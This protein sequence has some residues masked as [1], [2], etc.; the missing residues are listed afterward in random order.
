MHPLHEY[1]AKQVLEHIRNRGVLVWY[2]TRK[3][4]ASFIGEL[5]AESKTGSVVDVVVEFTARFNVA[6]ESHPPA[7]VVVNV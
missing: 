7:L 5:R 4:F 6:T 2:D 1:I 3:D